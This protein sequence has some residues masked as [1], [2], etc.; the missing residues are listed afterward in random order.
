M[1]K[2]TDVYIMLGPPNSGKGTQAAWIAEKLNLHHLSS[3][4]AFRDA[5]RSNS[6]LGRLASSYLEAGNLVPDDVAI[7][8]ILQ[9]LQ[10]LA[11]DGLGTIL[12]GF[13]RTLEQAE[14]LGERIGDIGLRIRAV[15][16]IEVGEDELLRRAALR[17]RDDDRPEVV[18]K[19][20][21]VYR[22]ITRPLVG[23]YEQRELLLRIDGDRPAEAVTRAILDS[24]GV[25]VT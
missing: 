25:V 2:C 9:R 15:L 3:G 17:G 20:F 24:I 1:K 5:V 12:D 23:Y 8:V 19:R 13:P 10:E 18:N 14:A 16:A 7:D 4:S 22:R 6:E 11:G 21:E